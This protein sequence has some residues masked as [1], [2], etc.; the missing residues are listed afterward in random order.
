MVNLKVEIPEKLHF[1]FRPHRYKVAR[2]GRGSAKS[3]SFAR[4]LLVHGVIDPL[5]ILCT[6]EI[7][8]SIKDSVHKLLADQIEAMG[9]SGFYT[10]QETLIKGRNGTE[11]IFSGLS[12]QTI[13]SIKSFEG[14][15]RCWCEEG[16]TIQKRSWD[17][18]IPTIRKDLSEIWVSYNPDLETDETHQRFTVHPP[19]DCINVEMNW[20]DNPWFNDVLNAER[21]RCKERDPDNYENIWE[22]KCRPA[23]E[24][25]I[26]YKEVERAQTNGQIVPLPYD[27][28]LKVHVVVDLGWNDQMSIALVQRQ[29]SS[30][31]VIDYIEDSHRTI[32]S[33]SAELKGKQLNWGKVWLPHDGFSGDVKTGKTCEAI[34]RSLGWDVARKDDIVQL[35][36]E[37][38]IKNARM[39]FHRV[40]FDQHKTERLVECLKRYRR[41]VSRATNEEST[42]VHDEFSHGADCFRY[43]CCNADQMHNEEQ[44][45]R[46]IIPG[47]GVLDAV[48]GY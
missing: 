45:R 36:V 11:F 26:Y 2:G 40:Y 10:I 3:W 12:S 30:I 9:M 18:L 47:Y 27:P 20:S 4:A 8:N 37:D 42:P 34:F 5:R 17:I 23:V 15:D 48:I 43:I 46:P 25:A 6:R 38:G 14:I 1:L 7:Q 29:Q 39:S 33:Y 13:E 28:M 22:G 44:K 24:G 19:E 21:K 16:Q 32:D 41:K 35:S 31:R